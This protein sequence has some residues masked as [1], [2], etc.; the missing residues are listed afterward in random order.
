MKSH[1]I[2]ARRDSAG[3]AHSA[4]KGAVLLVLAGVLGGCGGGASAAAPPKETPPPLPPLRLVI[5]L[6]QT[7]S[8]K[9]T[10][11]EGVTVDAIRP[12]VDYVKVR[13][14]EILVLAIRSNSAK[15]PDA[16]LRVASAPA[17]PSKPLEGSDVYEASEAARR[18]R[19]TLAEYEAKNRAR[20][21]AVEAQVDTF[22][23]AVGELLAAPPDR[24]G[25][26][27]GRAHARAARFLAD[28]DPPQQ[29]PAERIYLVHSDGKDTVRVVAIRPFP[30]QLPVR[31]LLVSPGEAGALAPLEPLVFSSFSAATHYLMNGGR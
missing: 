15:T 30:A 1:A 26:D 23:S 9:E 24:I 5:A 19:R 2:N 11:S 21:A 6:D 18:Y 10:W 17:P 7:G 20:T 3:R 13:G 4:I 16:T 22:L 31:T 25:T 8:M 27:L 28:P 14:G 12:L 29:V